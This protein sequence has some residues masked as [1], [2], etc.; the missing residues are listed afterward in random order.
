MTHDGAPAARSELADA[1]DRRGHPLV[2][3]VE[4][5]LE[6]RSIAVIRHDLD[7]LERLLEARVVPDYRD[8]PEFKKFFDEDYKRM[9]AAIKSIGKL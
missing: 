6:L 7:L 5:L 9:A 4:E 2:I 1:L 8:A 3:L